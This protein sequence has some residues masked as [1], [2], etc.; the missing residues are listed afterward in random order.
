MP[1][2]NWPRWP[3]SLL[4]KSAQQM[5]QGLLAGEADP[6]TLAEFARGRRRSKR[7]QLAQALSGFLQPHHRVVIVEHLAHS[8][9]LDES[10]TRRSRRDC[11]S[12]CVP[13]RGGSSGW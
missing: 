1:T 3:A 2:S 10:M 6:A 13:T 9:A 7:E 5:L 8:D 4:G 11:S 12:G